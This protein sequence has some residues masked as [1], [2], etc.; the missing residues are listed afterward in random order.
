MALLDPLG[1]ALGRA[2][3]VTGAEIA[4]HAECGLN[5]VTG[6]LADLEATGAIEYRRKRGRGYRLK[7]LASPGEPPYAG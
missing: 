1:F 4:E 5:A 7:V 3:W 2:G 6:A